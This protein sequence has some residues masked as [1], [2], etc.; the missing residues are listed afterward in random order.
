MMQAKMV[1]AQQSIADMIAGKMTKHK[2]VE[3]IVEKVTTGFQ[4]RPKTL[5]KPVTVAKT[6]PIKVN[7]PVLQNGAN[8]TLK[9][10]YRGESAV[11]IDVWTDEG[12]P[13]SF[14]KTTLAAW[15]VQKDFGGDWVTLTMP[16]SVAKKRGLIK[17]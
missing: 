1:Y 4:V 9:M 8:V 7:K 12:K 14:G 17:G 2:G 10:K 3:Y 5:L 15:Q 6:S 11:Y 13:M 16:M